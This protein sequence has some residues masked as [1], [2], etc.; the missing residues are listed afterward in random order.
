MMKKQHYMKPEEYERYRAY[1]QGKLSYNKV[2]TKDHQEVYIFPI[3]RL[4]VQQGD[5]KI[6]ESIFTFALQNNLRNQIMFFFEGYSEDAREIT[7][8]P[9]CVAYVH[10]LNEVF[11]G[12]TYFMSTDLESSALSVLLEMLVVYRKAANNAS[13]EYIAVSNDDLRAIAQE[14]MEAM[15]SLLTLQ[16]PHNITAMDIAEAKKAISD[17]IDGSIVIDL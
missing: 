2:L 1:Q 5:A 10:G 11:P 14:C 13:S 16:F 9:E 4:C 7:E 3:P 17:Y 12:W 8:I 6:L 15:N